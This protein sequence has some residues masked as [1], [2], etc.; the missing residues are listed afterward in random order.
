MSVR[1]G[2]TRLLHHKTEQYTTVSLTTARLLPGD[3]GG[4]LEHI[5]LSKALRQKVVLHTPMG[6]G[7]RVPSTSV[8]RIPPEDNAA[9]HRHMRNKAIL[10][11]R[12]TCC[13]VLNDGAQTSS[14]SFPS[15]FPSPSSS[16]RYPPPPSPPRPQLVSAAP[17]ATYAAACYPGR[18]GGPQARVEHHCRRA[19]QA[20]RQCAQAAAQHWAMKTVAQRSTKSR[21]YKRGAQAESTYRPWR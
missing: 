2:E 13:L 6:L 5:K 11:S 1:G 20:P 12:S 10:L 18:R 19:T 7:R 14:P 15:S 3:E 17:P 16:Q 4:V 21:G 8:D 9:T